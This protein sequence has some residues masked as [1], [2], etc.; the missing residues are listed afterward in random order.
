LSTTSES[1]GRSTRNFRSELDRTSERANDVVV[2]DDARVRV[3]GRT[4]LQGDEVVTILRVDE[5]HAFA[6]GER[7]G[8]HDDAFFRRV[9]DFALRLSKKRNNNSTPVR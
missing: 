5:H 9:A 2:L 8:A 3:K 7:G 1:V 4:G 6:V